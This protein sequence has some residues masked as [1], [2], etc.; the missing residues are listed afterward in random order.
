MKSKG[1]KLPRW[2]MISAISLGILAVAAFVT[3]LIAFDWSEEAGI[4]GQKTDKA[5]DQ[6]IVCSEFSR[7]SGQYVEDGRDEPVENVAA[8]LVTN[9]SDEFLDLATLTYLIDGKEATFVVTGLL[10]GSSAWVMEQNRM[11]IGK[12]VEFVRKDCVCSFRKQTQFANEISLTS[13]GTNLTATNRTGQTLKNVVVYYKSLHTD[14]NFLG[15]IT[16]RVS[17]GDVASGESVEKVAGHYST[18][19][20]Q[21]V[22][23]SWQEE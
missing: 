6:D 13:S 15:G 10:P 14:G 21:V 5:T 18:A 19:G 7:F 20:S 12:D 17:F 9:Q 4:T 3:A 1:P 8:M 23:I 11:S 22:R 2:Q 16:Y